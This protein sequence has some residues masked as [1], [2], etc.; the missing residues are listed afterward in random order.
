MTVADD[1]L[2]KY[3]DQ[4]TSGKLAG[5]KHTPA[6]QKQLEWL[7]SEY[8]RSHAPLTKGDASNYLTFV[9]SAEPQLKRLGIYA[10]CK[11]NLSY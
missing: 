11:F 7:P 6:S 10:V 1:F 3:E 5:W 4:D 2:H 9:L 8:K